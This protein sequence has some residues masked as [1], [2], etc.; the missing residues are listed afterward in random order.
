MRN[1]LSLKCLIDGGGERATEGELHNRQEKVIFPTNLMRHAAENHKEVETVYVYA[2]M[3]VY[4][5]ISV[6]LE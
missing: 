1:S 4:S 5:Y 3:C 2:C 6:S